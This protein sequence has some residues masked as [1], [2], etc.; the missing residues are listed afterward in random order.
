MPRFDYQNRASFSVTDSG[1]D[2]QNLIRRTQKL[3]ENY[4]VSH[5]ELEG[6]NERAGTNAASIEASFVPLES[7]VV[8][9]TGQSNT[10]LVT[11]DI[12]AVIVADHEMEAAGVGY[13]LLCGFYD[14]S[15]AFLD[16]YNLI[17]GTQ[18]TEFTMASPGV[19]YVSEIPCH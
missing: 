3:I 7:R 13:D 14:I 5:H 1:A 6:F 17:A 18:F 12:N 9:S 16:G 11:L 15:P 19:S 8:D 10:A 4:Q 2:W